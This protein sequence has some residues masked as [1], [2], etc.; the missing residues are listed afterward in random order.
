MNL[1][2]PTNPRYNLRMAEASSNQFQAQ[3]SGGERAEQEAPS[4]N[5]PAPL[6]PLYGR[7]TELAII[8]SLLQS[9]RLLT[10]TGPGG[11]GKTRLALAVAWERLTHN[12]HGV[13]FVSLAPLDNP[14]LVPD[15][16]AEA[17]GVPEQP[18]ESFWT[19]L[20]RFLAGRHYLLLLDNFEHL[21]AGAAPLGDLLV[22]APSV[23]ILAT[24]R[25]RLSLHGEQEF[26]VAPLAVP[27]GDEQGAEQLL[28][29]PAVRLFVERARAT[30]PE[31]RLDDHNG[32]AVAAICRLLDGLPLAIELA[33]ARS[34][35]FGPR[36]ILARLQ[37]EMRHPPATPAL[38]L[39]SV[40]ARDL[41]A[42]Q[43]TLRATIDWSY[44]LLLPTE[45][46]LFRRLSI[47]AG[48]CTVEAVAAICLTGEL[49]DTDPL[50][51]LSSLVEKNL[52]RAELG[53]A[54]EPRFVLLHVI[55]EYARERLEKQGEAEVIGRR[56]A[57]YFLAQVEEQD[58]AP[59]A[60]ESPH[61]FD[62]LEME[63]GNLRVAIAWAVAHQQ[64]ELVLHA[65]LGLRNLWM[66]RGH[67][68]EGRRWFERVLAAADEAPASLRAAGFHAL[69]VLC[70]HRDDDHTALEHNRCALALY[71]EVG[72]RPGI[73]RT[74]AQEGAIQRFLNHHDEAL[75]CLEESLRLARALEDGDLIV[76]ALVEMGAIAH[77]RQEYARTTRS[78]RRQKRS[79]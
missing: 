22:A 70:F 32:P 76:G 42:R 16:I 29:V 9:T 41:P 52:L 19:S 36:A 65:A 43:Q 3:P 55:R 11:A 78:S 23:T 24:S 21:L 7:G 57:H 4:H 5:L 18:G 40:G 44:H 26:P 35:L 34:R 79:P 46:S 12:L 59:T 8:E 30:R 54:G 14:E 63:H 31:F 62:R 15:R 73:A 10:L 39:L 6:T 56:H 1:Q 64:V 60:P 37:G 2:I 20:Q 58:Q 69:A 27:S 68:G 67:A 49:H 28:H 66:V 77:F 72:D 33:A 75:V 47:F 48:G 25:E 50:P 38:T 13:T 71:R 61:R 53:P 45:Q 51:L 17:L 74:L